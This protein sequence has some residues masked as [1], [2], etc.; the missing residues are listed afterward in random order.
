MYIAQ[1]ATALYCYRHQYY[2]HICC[3]KVACDE[4]WSNWG[5]LAVGGCIVEGTVFFCY[6]QFAVDLISVPA[7]H[8][9]NIVLIVLRR[10]AKL[11]SCA[12]FEV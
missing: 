8:F 1:R 7:R 10:R 9:C 5:D 11:S 12:D 2:I 4:V 3:I 6:F